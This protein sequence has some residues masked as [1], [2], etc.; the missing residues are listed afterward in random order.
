L[1]PAL[2]TALNYAERGWYVFPIQPGLKLP[3]AGFSWKEKST[4]IVDT[5]L[6]AAAHPRYK[7]CNWAL[8]CGKSGLLITDYDDPTKLKDPGDFGLLVQT[9]RDGFHG[10]S[11]GPGPT[12]ASR[13]DA[14]IDTRGVGG[15]V[16]IPGSVNGN[17]KPYK[18]VHDRGT[19]SRAPDYIL[20]GLGPAGGVK[21]PLDMAPRSN[22]AEDLLLELDHPTNVQRAKDYLL[23]RAPEA[24]E[25]AGGDAT[26]YEVAC[27]VRDHG[28]SEDKALD[29]MFTSWNYY[30]AQPPWDIYEL[31][32]KVRNA[33][34]YAKDSIGNATP[35]KLFQSDSS[36]IFIHNAKV[37]S[38]LKPIEW[39]IEDILV[40]NSLYYDFGDPGSFKTFIALDRLLCIAA[41]I[42]YH[43]HK[44]QQGSVFYVAGEGQQGLGRRIAAWHKAH[45]TKALDIPFFVAR[46]PTQLMDVRALDA[47]MG[48][49]ERLQAEFGDPAVVHLD[50]L[51][52]NF[53]A[54]DESATK[55]MN[56]VIQNLDSAFG[57][58]FCRG[59]THHTGHF[60]KDRARGSIALHGAADAAFRMAQ[61]PE[62]LQVIAECKK[63]KDAPPAM[64]ILFDLKL[65][66]L[67][68][69][70]DFDQSYVMEKAQ[71][72]HDVVE[73]VGDSGK[74]S[75]AQRSALDILEENEGTLSVVKWSKLCLDRGV[76]KR[77]DGFLR[78]IAR[79]AK[80][81]LTVEADDGSSVSS[82]LNLL[83]NQEVRSDEEVKRSETE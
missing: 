23:Y 46:A 26:T 59:I 9:P 64:P 16:L 80:R 74:L 11:E 68:I 10:Y 78:G 49:I 55:D 34:T 60:N 42:D 56:T 76:Y 18:M 71:E 48:E 40:K 27:A 13:I 32:R 35:Q 6:A 30:K 2:K 47:I 72:G 67:K 39:Q 5:V 79:L 4:N 22:D 52:R 77:N 73:N 45:G 36:P 1:T 41:G 38:E 3:Y 70:S 44:V 62:R 25:G 43:G 53:G 75:E 54:G 58:D 24:I 66:R 69:G 29:L 15:Y 65:I 33:Y 17:G 37:L 28:I 12:S 51:S 61:V 82:V 31:G 21:D 8:D 50:T 20:D 7:D 57:T 63:Q 81:G 14:G 19:L 83:K